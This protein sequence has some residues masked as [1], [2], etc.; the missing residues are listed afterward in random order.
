[1]ILK[2]TCDMICLY[3]I[4]IGDALRVGYH[5]YNYITNNEIQQLPVDP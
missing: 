5:E 1:M 2:M 4:G 3:V